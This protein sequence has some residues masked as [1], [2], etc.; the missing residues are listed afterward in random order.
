MKVERNFAG[1]D[2]AAISQLADYLEKSPEEAMVRNPRKDQSL[3]Q[4]TVQGQP[5]IAKQYVHR[6]LK[7]RLASFFGQ[8]NA[9]RYCA[10]ADYL[11]QRGV[12]VPAPVL[13]LK[14]GSGPLPQRSLYVME[15]VDGEMLLPQI[16]DLEADPDRLAIVARKVAGLIVKL[17]QAGVIHRDLNTK[18]LLLSSENAI[19][20]ID[21]DHA[22][23]HRILGNRF[24]RRQQ[25][26]IQ[27]FLSTCHEGPKLAEAV[28]TLLA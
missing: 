15:S 10:I 4:V 28:R 24:A 6:A 19:R 8:S 17:C 26:D 21:F 23:R 11:G 14:T 3:F 2:A 25:R 27:T 13:L 22:S 12:P 1:L 9:D 20:L 5:V 7:H 18:N 16:R